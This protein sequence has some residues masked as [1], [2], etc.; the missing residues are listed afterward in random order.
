MVRLM[1]LMELTFLKS[2]SGEDFSFEGNGGAISDSD[3]VRGMLNVGSV[4]GDG[5]ARVFHV[6]A[7]EQRLKVLELY[8]EAVSS[9]ELLLKDYQ[10]SGAVSAEMAEALVYSFLEQWKR[11]PYYLL[12]ITLTQE[13]VSTDYLA[14]HMVNTLILVTGF[15]AAVGFSESDLFQIGCIAFLHDVGMLAVRDKYQLTRRLNTKE[16]QVVRQHPFHSLEAVK[17]FLNRESCE[18]ILDI[19]ERM[20]GRG[21]PKSKLHHQIHL[22]ARMIML[23]DIYDALIHRR[24][25]RVRYNPFEAIKMLIQIKGSLLEEGMIKKFINYMGLYPIGSFVVLN[26]SEVAQV[27]SCPH[28]I[29][30]KPSVQVM[31]TPEKEV[32]SQPRV[33]DLQKDSLITIVHAANEDLSYELNQFLGSH[34]NEG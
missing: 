15:A 23:C 5:R 12:P 26:S 30:T 4:L 33:I 11:Y 1:K 13:D 7:L 20:N 10:G 2:K 28:G 31:L 25:Y 8:R 16:Y 9:T 24:S 32:V 17:G 3:T 6:E 34:P 21:Y 27:M 29:P 22:W 19:H 14:G 18:I